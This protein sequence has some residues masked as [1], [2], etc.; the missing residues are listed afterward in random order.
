MTGRVD[1]LE[2]TADVGFR[3]AGGSFEEA[4]DAAVRGLATIEVGDP[5]PEPTSE[6]TATF[7]GDDDEALVVALLEECLYLVDAEQWLACGA[8]VRCGDDRRCEAVLQGADLPEDAELHVKAITWHGL[9]VERSDGETVI[10]VFL[11]I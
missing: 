7:E 9:S 8:A 10:T 4:L 3:A 1:I 5:L 6:R 2:H 11:D